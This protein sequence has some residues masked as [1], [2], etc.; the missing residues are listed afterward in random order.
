MTDFDGL[1]EELKGLRDEL[2]LKMHLASLELKDEWQE[3]EGK[4]ESFSSRAGLEAS[5]ES[6]GS[7]LGLLGQEIKTSYHRMK[8]ALKD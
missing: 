6:V 4:W 3:L 1:K 7:A 8:E 2:D 5:A